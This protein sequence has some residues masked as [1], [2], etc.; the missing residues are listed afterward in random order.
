MRHGEL[1]CVGR[2]P[3]LPR[4]GRVLCVPIAVDRLVSPGVQQQQKRSDFPVFAFRF[5]AVYMG[6]S[7]TV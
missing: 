1:T 4:R 5:S 3:G 7:P 6:F 2:D